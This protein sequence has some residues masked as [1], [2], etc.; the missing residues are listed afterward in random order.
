MLEELEDEVKPHISC[1]CGGE[2]QE[3]RKIFTEI[4]RPPVVCFENADR[5]RFK[6]IILVTQVTFQIKNRWLVGRP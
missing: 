5:K 4:R 1:S 6:Q 2:I 3:G